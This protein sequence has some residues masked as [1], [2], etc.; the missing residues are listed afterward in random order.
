MAVNARIGQPVPVILPDPHTLFE[1]RAARLDSLAAG[2]P[3]GDWL[4]FMARLARAQRAAVAA[5]PAAA[6]VAAA[7]GEP[8][9][10]HEA[11][12]REP[13]WQAGLSALLEATDDVALPDRARMALG[14]LAA[15]TATELEALAD[16]CLRGD[17]RPAESGPAVFVAAALA[18]Y[19]AHR[20]A[21][22]PIAQIHLLAQRG[23]C[24]VCGGVPVAGV[25]TAAGTATGVRY[26]QCGLCATAW[27]H[28]RAVCTACG[29]SR[30]LVLH[31]IEGGSDVVLAETCDECRGYAKV[32]YQARDMAVE[33]MADDLA[34]LGL[35]M[36]VGE[37][38]YHRHAPN[39]LVIG[40]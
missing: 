23:R 36:L 17:V 2:H 1:R 39:P 11:H 26:L 18:A 40:G 25:V 16:R 22:L 3:M 9:L 24:P 6:T 13:W 10:T 34:S 4:R 7:E 30:G 5:F 38:G 15:G 28:V 8:P 35:D 21:A 29:E 33:P 14:A 12:R 20:A 32:L 37:A 27:N 31:G 19:F